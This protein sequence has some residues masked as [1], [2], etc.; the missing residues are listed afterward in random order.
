MYH[1]GNI[2]A[3][4]QA[5]V[6]DQEYEDTRVKSRL[7]TSDVH[8]HLHESVGPINPS[9]RRRTHCPFSANVVQRR[10]L[11]AVILDGDTMI[12]HRGSL[13][14]ANPPPHTATWTKASARGRVVVRGP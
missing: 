14:R 10:S 1:P 8:V 6:D 5:D 3:E 2:S 11:V 7:C 12:D 4:R 13:G 9:S